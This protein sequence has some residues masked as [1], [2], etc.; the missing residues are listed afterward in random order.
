MSVTII[1]DLAKAVMEQEQQKRA[2]RNN[3]AAGGENRENQPAADPASTQDSSK[4]EK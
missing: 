4:S 1:K 3:E 2:R